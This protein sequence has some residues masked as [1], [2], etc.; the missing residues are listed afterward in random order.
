MEAPLFFRRPELTAP[1]TGSG[2]VSTSDASDEETV[3][4]PEAAPPEPAAAEIF[5]V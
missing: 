5:L 4:V 1:F 3:S 2:V